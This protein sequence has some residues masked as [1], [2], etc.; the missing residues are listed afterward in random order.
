MNV[1]PEGAG[2]GSL[3]ARWT[4]RVLTALISVTVFAMMALTTADVIA[5][6]LFNAPMKGN[7]EIVT[8]LLAILI[9]ASLPLV[10]WDEGHITVNLFDRWIPRPAK[11]VLDVVLSAV[12]TF[13]VAGI[14]Y[15]L[16]IQGNLMA[17]GQHITGF[18]EWPIAPIAYFTSVLSGLT[19]IVL[20]VITWQK[21]V[22]PGRPLSDTSVP[23]GNDRGAG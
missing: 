16:W 7:F 18:L 5:R 17:E 20:V 9:F 13:V 19:T 15:R 21:I 23:Y 10:T 12:S 4:R 8:F 11:W 2:V 6:A 3:V 22:R 14:T 1:P